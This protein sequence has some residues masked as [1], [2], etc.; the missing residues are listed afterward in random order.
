MTNDTHYMAKTTVEGIQPRKEEGTAKEKANPQRLSMILHG[1]HDDNF[2]FIA[3]RRAHGVYRRCTGLDR[4]RRPFKFDLRF[5]CHSRG[6]QNEHENG[7]GVGCYW[8]LG[9]HGRCE[10]LV[11]E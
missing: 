1:S 8:L 3:R 10:F 5:S 2:H 4:R 9:R 7:G 11:K 6:R